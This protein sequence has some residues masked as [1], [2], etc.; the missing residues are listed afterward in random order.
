[1]TFLQNTINDYETL[2]ELLIKN[3]PSTIHAANEKAA[4]KSSLM[5]TVIGLEYDFI[6]FNSKSRVSF[7]VFDIDYKED[8]TAREHYGSIDGLLKD[9]MLVV[10]MEPSYICETTKGY[11]FAYHLKNWVFTRQQKAY[12]F[13]TVIKRTIASLLG[14]DAVASNRHY[15]IFRNPMRHRFYYSGCINY[16]LNDFKS[17]LTTRHSSASFVTTSSATPTEIIAT[18]NRNNELFCQGMKWAK[19][20]NEITPHDIGVYLQTINE[21]FSDTPLEI[22]EIDGIARSVYKYWTTDRIRFGGTTAC[23]NAGIMGFE[24]ITGVNREEYERLVKER[25]Q[26]SAER[27]NSILTKEQKREAMAKARDVRTE[28]IQTKI[29]EALAAYEVD[30]IVPKNA[31]IARLTGINRKTIAK[32]LKSSDAI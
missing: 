26:L 14:C 12:E 18:G 5:K 11:Q 19:G 3:L 7:M 29:I 8:K 24:K 9:I 23:E 30:G 28:K 6:S 32:Y 17:L 10:G 21:S 31:A 1:M 4:F 22:M 16:E 13:M 27:T 15:G 25:R 20:K 2:K